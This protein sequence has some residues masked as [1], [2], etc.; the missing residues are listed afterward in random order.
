MTGLCVCYLCVCCLVYTCAHANIQLNRYHYFGLG[1][2]FF[3]EIT[4]PCVVGLV[5]VI[6]TTIRFI[7]CA[8]KFSSLQKLQIDTINTAIIFGKHEILQLNSKLRENHSI[9]SRIR[10]VETNIQSTDRMIQQLTSQ[11]V[12]EN[13]S[14]ESTSTSVRIRGD[15]RFHDHDHGDNQVAGNTT[16]TNDVDD[17]RDS[18]DDD[19]DDVME[20]KAF[21]ENEINNEL[22]VSSTQ[23]EN[24]NENDNGNRNG[25]GGH[26]GAIKFSQEEDDEDRYTESVTNHTNRSYDRGRNGGGGAIKTV[27]HDEENGKDSKNVEGDHDVKN[28]I[29]VSDESEKEAGSIKSDMEI[30]AG[31]HVVGSTE[32]ETISKQQNNDHALINRN[33]RN[34]H[35]Q[36]NQSNEN[37]NQNH[38]STSNNNESNINVNNLLSHPNVQVI[39][40]LTK[41][42]NTSKTPH[43]LDGL[44]DIVIPLNNGGIN[45][46]N[47]NF[48]HPF[49]S[50]PF[51]GNHMHGHGIYG[52]FDLGK[53]NVVGASII[54][55]SLVYAT[56]VGPNVG[57]SPNMPNMPNINYI[58]HAFDDK[59]DDNRKHEIEFEKVMA[60]INK[61]KIQKREQHKEL[62]NLLNDK[63][64]NAFFIENK[65]KH[66]QFMND[67]LCQVIIG[68]QTYSVSPKIAGLAL[69]TAFIKLA[70]SFAL[71][72]VSAGVTYYLRSI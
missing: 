38:A 25:N 66:Y 48:H 28:D 55:P 53:F 67:Y 65:I 70:I 4:A 31:D 9:S 45:G 42:S 17:D 2:S 11:V 71:T 40:D 3:N 56:N 60:Q 62:T 14:S 44:N 15:H 5:Y 64:N 46:H 22:K 68:I 58:Q 50:I 6:I 33:V 69:D 49:L 51:G 37:E 30:Y 43:N 1:E 59:I 24:E 61:L 13:D 23:N 10:I 34:E 57:I 8:N 63:E 47:V 7:H 54:P 35:A 19:N 36:F 52:S 72:C 20:K 32:M 12:N 41:P 18:D 16:V 39:H 29:E 21:G 26:G 27:E